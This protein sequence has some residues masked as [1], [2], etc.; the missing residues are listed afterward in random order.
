MRIWRAILGA[1]A[2]WNLVI[3]GAALAGP[4]TSLEARIVGLLVACFGIAYAIVA[5][6]PLRLRA[7]LWAGVVGKAGIVA[8]MAPGVVAGTLPAATGAILAGDA[9]FT[10]AFLVLLLRPRVAATETD[11]G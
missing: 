9:I 10:L 2:L 11:G 6:D 4:A 3:G 1:A 5:T 7:V 8:L